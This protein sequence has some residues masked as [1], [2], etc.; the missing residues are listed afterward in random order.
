MKDMDLDMPWFSHTGAG[1]AMK[2]ISVV[3]LPE[4]NKDECTGLYEENKKVKNTY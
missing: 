3:R 1:G 4:V 2:S